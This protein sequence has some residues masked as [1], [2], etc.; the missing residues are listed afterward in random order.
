MTRDEEARLVKEAQSGSESAFEA[1]MLAN[2]NKVYSLALKTCGNRED[3]LDIS[4]EV[5]IKAYTKLSSF[6]GDSLFSVWL[7]RLTYNACVDHMRKKRGEISLS[8]EG[9]DDEGKETE[10]RDERALPEEQAERREL[11]NAVRKAVLSLP[12]DK[13]MILVMR[14]FSGMSYDDIAESLGIDIG[15]V[16]SRIARARQALAE[17]ISKDGTFSGLVPSKGTKGGRRDG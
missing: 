5:F 3:A 10:L 1:L 14:E 8:R 4:Q 16:K 13:R 6:R 11:Q 17:I 2:Q 12:D 7:Y 9:D 15:T